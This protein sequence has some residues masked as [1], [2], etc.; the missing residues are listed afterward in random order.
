MCLLHHNYPCNIR[1][2]PNNFILNFENFIVIINLNFE[3]E[4]FLIIA[5]IVTVI[6]MT[7]HD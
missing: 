4:R 1:Q 5:R 7:C 3:F 2:P 6:G